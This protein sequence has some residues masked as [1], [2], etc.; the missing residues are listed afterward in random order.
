MCTEA[1]F[2]IKPANSVAYRF[3]VR[4]WSMPTYASSYGGTVISSSYDSASHTVTGAIRNDTGHAVYVDATVALY[5]ASAQILQC[6]TFPSINDYS[7]DP[8]QITSFK[9]KFYDFNPAL[10][11]ILQQVTQYSVMLSKSP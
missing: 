5:D 2:N 8:G 9:S 7:L 1:V 10:V 6:D 11:R 4:G 3:R